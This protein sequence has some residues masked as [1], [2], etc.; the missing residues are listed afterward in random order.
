[1]YDQAPNPSFPHRYPVTCS[2]KSKL[3]SLS[4]HHFYPPLNYWH[5]SRFLIALPWHI[6]LTFWKKVNLST[7]LMIIYFLEYK[8][9]LDANYCT[10]FNFNHWKIAGNVEAHTGLGE[11]HR[12]HFCFA[13]NVSPTS[14]FIIFEIITQ[15]IL[16]DYSVAG[17]FS[18]AN[19]K[20][21]KI[22]FNKIK[23]N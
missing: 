16:N 2:F 4:E 17:S 8:E 10:R 19:I 15:C 13:R 6:Y 22:L 9:R 14:F 23:C 11:R 12:E 7:R 20:P 21:L 3:G 5:I 1:M 18:N